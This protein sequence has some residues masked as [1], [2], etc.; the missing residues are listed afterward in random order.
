MFIQAPETRQSM[1]LEDV[2]KKH[3]SNATPEQQAN[4]KKYFEMKAKKSANTAG[5][6]KKMSE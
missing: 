5:Y 2:Y 1:M 6:Y 3:L 4:G